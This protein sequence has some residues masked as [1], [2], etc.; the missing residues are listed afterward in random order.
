MFNVALVAGADYQVRV[1]G[2]T[3]AGVGVDADALVSV[4]YRVPGE[5]VQVDISLTLC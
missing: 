3:D 4:E 1:L 5:T 2:L